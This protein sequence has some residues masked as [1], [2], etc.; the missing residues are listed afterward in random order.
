VRDKI[1]LTHPQKEIMSE[2]Y[3]VPARRILLD[4][5]ERNALWEASRKNAVATSTMAWINNS[6]PALHHQLTR[7]EI[8]QNNIQSAVFSECVYA[9]AL[10]DIFQLSCFRNCLIDATFL[11]TSVAGLL[12]SYS[13]VPRYAYMTPDGRRMLIQAGGC[14]GVDSALITVFDLKIFTIE[15]KEPWA[16][17]SEPDLP[18]YGEDGMLRA[19]EEFLS[20]YPQYT[21]MLAEKA[22]LNFFEIMGRNVNDFTAES[23]NQ[24]IVENYCRK[25]FADVVCTE[26]VCA[27]LVMLP[28]NQVSTWARIVG[29]IRPAGRNHF[30]VW[31]PIAL[32]GFLR[33]MGATIEAGVVQVPITRLGTARPRGGLGVS[34]YKINSLFFVRAENVEVDNYMAQFKLGDVR[35][36]KPTIAAKMLFDSL[37]YDEVKAHYADQ[38]LI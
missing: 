37:S 35:Q 33:A 10:A 13:L 24:A 27:R 19:T 18:E 1:P 38:C 12:A 31:T 29:E 5:Q 26:D 2:F 21:S 36:L 15:F 34:R 11:P 32:G 30:K 16:K 8:G 6:C 23:V 14:G 25:K 22:G 4:K 17:A 3:L 9:Q 20:R 7:H 28:I